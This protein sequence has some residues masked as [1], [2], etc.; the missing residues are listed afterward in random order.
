MWDGTYSAPGKR[1]LLPGS[2]HF[3]HRLFLQVVVNSKGS[4]SA[5]GG[6]S[7]YSSDTLQHCGDGG[8]G[9][10]IQV[11]ST[12]DNSTHNLFSVNGGSGIEDGEEGVAYQGGKRIIEQFAHE[13]DIKAQSQSRQE[14]VS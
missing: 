5:A 9:G 1:D 4:L 6:H 8:G 10:V 2:F 14:F 3:L 11:F 7:G 12:F 13:V